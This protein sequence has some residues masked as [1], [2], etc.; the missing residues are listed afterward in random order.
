MMFTDTHNVHFEMD[1]RE[2][3]L[4]I[5]SANVTIL[6][7]LARYKIL[8][9]PWDRLGVVLVHLN[10]EKGACFFSRILERNKNQ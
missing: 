1:V 3:S 10:T 7:F 2:K 9:S 5:Q 8:Q 6:L 4:T